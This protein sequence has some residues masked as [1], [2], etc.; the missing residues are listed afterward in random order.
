[1]EISSPEQRY[2]KNIS[3]LSEIKVNVLKHTT[4]SKTLSRTSELMIESGERPS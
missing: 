3:D 1:V 4:T 2:I